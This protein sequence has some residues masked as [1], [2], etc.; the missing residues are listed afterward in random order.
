MTGGPKR[1]SFTVPPFVFSALKVWIFS[2]LKRLR[3]SKMILLDKLSYVYTVECMFVFIVVFN[4]VI[5][6]KCCHLTFCITEVYST[7]Q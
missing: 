1:L 6:E 5:Q 7:H 3:L 2:V 4:A